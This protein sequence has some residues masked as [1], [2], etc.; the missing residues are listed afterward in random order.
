MKSGRVSRKRTRRRRNPAEA[1]GLRVPREGA[2][3]A[4]AGPAAADGTERTDEWSTTAGWPMPI[5]G[6]ASRGRE[7]RAGAR[8]DGPGLHQVR[9]PARPDGD[10]PRGRTRAGAWSR[11]TPNCGRTK[12]FPFGSETGTGWTDGISTSVSYSSRPENG[13]SSGRRN[14]TW[15]PIGN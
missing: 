9:R 8:T 12:A 3:L 10:A 15:I 2:V 4:Q 11:R 5:C 6:S 1:N 13:P 7:S 14:D